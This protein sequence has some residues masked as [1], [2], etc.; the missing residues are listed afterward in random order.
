MDAVRRRLPEKQGTDSWFFLYD[1]APAH[2]SS[3]VKDFLAKNTVTTLEKPPNSFDLAP[4]DFFF[5]SLK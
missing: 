2:Q 4:A 3:L 1:Y 5:C